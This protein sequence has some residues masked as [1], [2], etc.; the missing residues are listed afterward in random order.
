M[1]SE[2]GLSRSNMTKEKNS[3]ILIIGAGNIGRRHLQ[4]FRLS[5][6]VSSLLVVDP[7]ADALSAAKEM[8]TESGMNASVEYATSLDDVGDQIDAAIVATSA[9]GRLN[10]LRALLEMGVSNIILEKIAFNSLPDI[11]AAEAL[12]SASNARVWVNC[13]RRIYPFYQ[14]LKERLSGASFRRV[15]V[16]GNN[17]GLGSN[18]I[19]FIDIFS[20][21]IGCADYRLN[22]DRITEVVESK[23]AGYVEFFGSLVG[24]F[25]NGC[26]LELHCEHN[27]SDGGIELVFETDRGSV[28]VLEAGGNIEI[29]Q[30][31]CLD[32]TSG[33][34]PYQSE[35]SG[36]LF[37]EMLTTGKCG[38]TAFGESMA[39]HRPFIGAAYSAYARHFG[40]N[41]GE[42]V[43][44]T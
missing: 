16:R 17:Y 18:G 28:T 3:R 19:H 4:S 31:G 44:I 30:D 39:L 7:F 12:V 25:S 1:K 33:K 26:E 42:I 20:Y 23:R 34:A 40:D 29:R 11:S 10:I 21:I 5:K 32:A 27:A 38:L 14:A 15:S 6:T 43:P 9:N 22:G 41:D 24:Q 8:V 2:A 37:D 36:L 13:P 35:L